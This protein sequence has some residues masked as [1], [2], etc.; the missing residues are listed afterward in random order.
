MTVLFADM[1]G[2]MELLA[3]RD[4]EDARQILDPV[5]ERMI[6]AVHRYEGTVNQVM[7]DGIMALFGAPV[8]YE[9]H[10]LRACYAALAMQESINRL[11]ADL[12]RRGELPVQIRVGVN[13]GEVVVRSVESGLHLDY[14]AVG[15][16]THVAGRLEQITKP[17]SILISADTFRLVEGYVHVRDIGRVPVKGLRDLMGVYELI[18]TGPARRRIEALLNRGLSRFVGRE[19]ELATLR[20]ALAKAR[21]GSGQIVAV[22]GE[23]GVGK[24]RLLWEFSRSSDIQEW[25]L[26]ESGAVSYGQGTAY[27]PLVDILRTYFGIEGADHRQQIEEKISRKLVELDEVLVPMIPAF[28]TLVDVPVDT[29]EWTRLDPAQRRRRTH[30]ACRRL[31]VRESQERP[32]LLVLEDLHWLDSETQA[33]LEQFFDSLPAAR[34][35]FLLSY[36]PEFAHAWSGKSSY[37]HLRID[38]LPPEPA[39]DLLRALV[40]VD[41]SL[42]PLKALLTAQ[43]EGNPLFLEESVRMLVETRILVGVNGN[44]RLEKP[45]DSIQVAPTVQAV[46][47]ARIDRLP[48]AEKQ[49][50]Q[51]AAVIGNEVSISILEA[52]M[53][54]SADDLRARLAALEASEF[55]YQVGFAEYTYKHALTHEV[56]YGEIVGTRRRPLHVSV[57]EAIERLSADRLGEQVE[58][59]AHHAVRGEA[60]TKALG[61]LR[62]A[63]AKAFSRSAHRAAVGYLEQALVALSRLPD[64]RETQ[65]QAIDVRFDLRNSLL[66]LGEH[67][68]Y[69]E[70]LREADA[71]AAQ[72]DDPHRRAWIA[73]Y[74]TAYLYLQGDEAGA[75]ASGERALRLGRSL[76]DFGLHVSTH[77]WVGQLH[78]HR[79]DYRRAAEHFQ[80]NVA[81]L[82]G[83]RI[84]ERFGLPQLP[85]VHSRTCL[86]WCFSELGE[87]REA[88]EL[89]DEGLRIARGADHPLS[90][91]IGCAGSGRVRLC[92]GDLDHAIPLLEQG[93]ALTESWGIRLWFP[94]LASA[95]GSAYALS[96]RI[97]D[98]MSLLQQAVDRAASM[99]LMGGHSLLVACLGEGHLLAGD[100][101]EAARLAQR[102]LDL[103]RRH[104]ERGHEAWALRLGAE[105]S[106]RSGGG[107]AKAATELCHQAM[108]LATEL[109]MRPV[110]AHSRFL[111]GLA[112]GLNGDTA[113]A[114]QSLTMAVE[115]FRELGMSRYRAHAELEVTRLG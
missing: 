77:T 36:R 11:A 103:A 59:L 100:G 43:T 65:E 22:V 25:R 111:H 30:E 5:L 66:P 45:V 48:A 101:N 69:V 3:D 67:A 4:P 79:G 86:A 81:T 34:V 95:L 6:A 47:S 26:L 62:R 68:R 76:Q 87:F 32:V 28:L 54:S 98:G 51:C 97:D 105:V 114:K 106:L 17:G 1:K 91:L 13:S 64:T 20:V 109:G 10:A 15:Q 40:G 38:P 60:W 27:L 39:D 53:S 113:E 71:I 42:R 56:A 33:F 94:R 99:G 46:L 35:L 37:T 49:V 72:L 104:N 18:G 14:S 73:A 61:Y 31:L 50:L 16:T 102:A 7:G 96:G 107:D 84:H 19:A 90:V 57:M 2:S 8:S 83:D 9:D 74:T 23:P 21:A 92:Q 44:Y 24:S 85:S 112:R 115:L 89:A 29:T 88:I 41:P 58:R 55:L 12:Q 63:A 70:Y 75:Q 52:V 82:T 80:R 108:T 78:Y 93:V 110:V